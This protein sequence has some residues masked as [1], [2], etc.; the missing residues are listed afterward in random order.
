MNQHAIAHTTQVPHAY[1]RDAASLALRVRTAAG[2]VQRVRV[3]YKDRYHRGFYHIRTLERVHHGA[4]FDHFETIIALPR[5]R[6]RYY[7]ELTDQEGTVRCL[8]ERGLRK[9]KL[10]GTEATAFQYAYIGPSDVYT[11]VPWLRDAVVYQ[12]F[13]DRFHRK[14][15][16]EEK[17]LPWNAPV[18]RRSFFGGNLSG[19]TEKLPYLEGLG[20]TVLYLTPVFAST[21]NHKYNTRDYYRIDPD[22][23]TLLDAKAL[24]EAAHARGIR[25]V[26]DLVFNH[27]GHDF[28]AFQDLLQNQEASPYR[29]W[30]HPDG[31]PVSYEAGNYY[32]FANGAR[33]MPKF[34]TQDPGLRR[35]LLEVAA[36]WME[37]LR[38]DGYRLD[39]CDELEHDFLKA[40]R[41][42]VKAVKPDAVLIGEIM[43]KSEA[44]LDGTELDSIMNYPFREAVLDYIARETMEAR[45]F[46]EALTDNLLSY[47]T[48]IAHQML[49]LVGSHDTPRYMT[50]C[51]GDAAK[52]AL[53]M[54]FQFLFPG[55]P[56]LYYGDEL[57]MKGGMDPKC[58]GTMD[59]SSAQAGGPLASLLVTLAGLRRRHPVLRHGAFRVGAMEGKAFAFTRTAPGEDPIL[60]Y[61]NAGASAQTL[62][63]EEPGPVKDL[64]ESR[65]TVLSTQVTLAPRSFRVFG[66]ARDAAGQR[67]RE[68]GDDVE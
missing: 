28:F 58:R 29:T 35:Y 63:V 15:A 39:V 6:Y 50:E 24:V 36:Y 52:V 8:D 62:S 46:V 4:D 56:Y 14:V 7:F 42:T 10:R 44:F 19:I 45:D 31:F 26:F 38:I 13:P 53:T 43:H 68:R 54:A 9:R 3:F 48:D 1:P 34:N 67:I 37:T 12:I 64:M 21:S 18:G 59:W 32:T 2:D 20:V 49:N 66:K 17:H 55:V 51:R 16:P 27:S 40:L 57:G 61:F 33:Y 22:F 23:G 47:R 65:D 60:V 25:V 5:N 30:Y 41:K 11:P